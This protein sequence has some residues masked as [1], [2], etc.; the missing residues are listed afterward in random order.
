MKTL[1]DLAIEMIEAQKNRIAAGEALREARQLEAE[2]KATFEKWL[3]YEVAD[4]SETPLL[5]DDGA[6][7]WLIEIN[8]VDGEIARCCPLDELFQTAKT[9]DNWPKNSEQPEGE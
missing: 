8:P 5:V 3:Q 2:A 4:P 6:Q 1:Y 7:K 9:L